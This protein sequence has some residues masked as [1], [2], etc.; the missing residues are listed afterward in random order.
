MSEFEHLLSY[1]PQER[2]LVNGGRAAEPSPVLAEA[3]ELLREE[4]AVGSLDLRILEWR[5]GKDHTL[6]RDSPGRHKGG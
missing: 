4:G 2:V 1:F 3:G 5:G 6:I